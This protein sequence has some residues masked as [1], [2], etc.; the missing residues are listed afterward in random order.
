MRCSLFL[1]FN[2]YIY[3]V[4]LILKE[5]LRKLLKEVS[6]SSH[7]LSEYLETDSTRLLVRFLLI[8]KPVKV[9]LCG[10]KFVLRARTDTNSFGTKNRR[11]WD[12]HFLLN[13]RS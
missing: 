7:T 5:E 2:I 4:F 1:F 9:V 6:V 11:H 12:Y 8:M 10:K 3:Q 13:L